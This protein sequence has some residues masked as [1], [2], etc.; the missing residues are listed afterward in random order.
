VD[1]VV[2]SLGRREQR[3]SKL[4]ARVAAYFVMALALF[5]AMGTRR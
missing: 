5:Y 3:K 1:E 4:P 2:L